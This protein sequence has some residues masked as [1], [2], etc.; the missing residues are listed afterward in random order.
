[1]HVWIYI[2][3]LI[4]LRRLAGW[5]SLMVVCAV[6]LPIPFTPTAR[7]TSEKDTSEP[8]PCMN[9]PCGCLSADQCWKK[10]CCFTNEQK[11]AWAKANDVKIPEFVI[12]AAKA[13]SHARGVVAAPVKPSPKTHGACCKTESNSPAVPKPS[14]PHCSSDNKTKSATTASCCSAK[15]SQLKDVTPVRRTKWVLAVYAA[16]CQGNGEFWFSMAP[17]ILLPPIVAPAIPNDTTSGE[18]LMSERLPM[19]SLLPPVPPPRVCS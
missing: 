11:V 14:C 17:A 4:N 3:K 9:R 16:R 13:E 6:V 18:P 15:K 8:F 1:M 2:R 19:T 10:C 5:A 7:N 12:V